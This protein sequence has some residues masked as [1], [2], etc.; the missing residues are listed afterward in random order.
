MKIL[1]SILIITASMLIIIPATGQNQKQVKPS[2]EKK[3]TPA[4]SPAAG[5][6]TAVDKNKTVKEKPDDKKNPTSPSPAPKKEESIEEKEKKTADNI[7]EVLKYGLQKERMIAVNKVLSI[8]TEATKKRLQALLAGIMKDEKDAD[9]KQKMIMVLG[10]LKSEEAIPAIVASLQSDSEDVRVA[11]AFALQNIKAVSAKDRLLEELDKQ[12][13]SVDS[14][15]TEALIR[16]LGSFGAA[17]LIPRAKKAV[18]DL[19]TTRNNRE[20]FVL[21]LGEIGRKDQGEFLLKLF[22][23]EEEH[24]TLRSYAVNSIAKIGMKEAGKD[25]NDMINEINSYSYKK[26]KQYY[27]LYIYSVAALAKLGDPEAVPH[28]ENALRSDSTEVRIK[29]AELMKQLK[30]KR[31]IDILKYKMEYDP[32]YKVRKLSR[33]ALKEMGVEVKDE[34][35]PAGTEEA[36]EE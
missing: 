5:P 12:D 19:K 28:L 7:E 16:A 10:E 17:E 36:G 34:T 15:Y 23:D 25:I 24:V 8:K 32:S 27:S 13:L 29:A 35:K 18:E 33:E 14:S 9:V 1:H 3:E 20:V 6:V 4:S 11:A 2:P 30:D 26:K 21:M 31:T 22:K